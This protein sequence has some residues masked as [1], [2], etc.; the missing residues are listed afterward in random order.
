[1]D[2]ILHCPIDVFKSYIFKKNG[3]QYECTLNRQWVTSPVK[4]YKR[5]WKI[6]PFL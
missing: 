3:S 1:M 5:V 6:F 2:I 4:F